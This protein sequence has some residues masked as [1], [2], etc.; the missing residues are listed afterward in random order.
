M[1]WGGHAWVMEYRRTGIVRETCLAVNRATDE[2]QPETVFGFFIPGKILSAEFLSVGYMRKI[3]RV[4]GRGKGV[5][6]TATATAAPALPGSYEHSTKPQEKLLSFL[7][8]NMAAGIAANILAEVGASEPVE[9]D[10]SEE[11]D[12]QSRALVP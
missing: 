6:V 7:T 3:W 4:N 10:D 9:D 2:F 12:T 5:T 11:N 8:R 1:N